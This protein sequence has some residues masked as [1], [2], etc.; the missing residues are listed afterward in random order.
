MPQHVFL[1]SVFKQP[2]PSMKHTQ[3]REG[4]FSYIPL[5]L[6]SS[7]LSACRGAV[8]CP[9]C[10]LVLPSLVAASGVRRS[11][12]CS[13]SGQSCPCLHS[14]CGLTEDTARAVPPLAAHHTPTKLTAQAQLTTAL[15]CQQPAQQN[16]NTQLN[17]LPQT[18]TPSTHQLSGLIRALPYNL[19]L[20]QDVWLH[21]TDL[22]RNNPKLC[23]ALILTQRYLKV[24]RRPTAST[25]LI[26]NCN[27]QSHSIAP[28]K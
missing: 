14:T 7:L 22:L 21:L 12:A 13:R 5:N 2:L 27:K 3:I 1:V 4:S 28:K 9:H 25:D 11:Q 10:Q 18:G 23:Q 8:P 26:A 17:N 20:L 6:P 15:P 16:L 19:G 24:M